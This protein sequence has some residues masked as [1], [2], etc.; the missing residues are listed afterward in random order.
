VVRKRDAADAQIVGQFGITGRYVAVY[1][2]CQ[3]IVSPRA[4]GARVAQ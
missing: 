3:D 2:S 4:F 1:E